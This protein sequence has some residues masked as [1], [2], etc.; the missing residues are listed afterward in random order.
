LENRIHLHRQT[1]S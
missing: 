1:W